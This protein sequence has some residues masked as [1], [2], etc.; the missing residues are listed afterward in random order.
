MVGEYI[1]LYTE[2]AGEDSESSKAADDNDTAR[3]VA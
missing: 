1:D 2:I 3:F